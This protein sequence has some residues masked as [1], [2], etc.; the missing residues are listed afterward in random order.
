[1]TKFTNLLCVFYVYMLKSELD[2][3]NGLNFCISKSLLNNVKI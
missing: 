3:K 2:T 1:M